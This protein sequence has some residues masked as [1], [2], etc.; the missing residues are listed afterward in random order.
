[1]VASIYA[2]YRELAEYQVDQSV[3]VPIITEG[4]ETNE[5]LC[6]ASE[7]LLD[8]MPSLTFEGSYIHTLENAEFATIL[9]E[10]IQELLVGQSAEEFIS[11]VDKSIEETNE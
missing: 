6:A 8:M 10:E 1:M 9:T 11:D 7:Q 4:Y 5:P 3:T 2:Y